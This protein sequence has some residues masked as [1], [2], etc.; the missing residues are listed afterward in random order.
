MQ[1]DVVSPQRNFEGVLLAWNSAIRPNLRNI[2]HSAEREAMFGAAGYANARA[3][4]L[5][6]GVQVARN[7]DEAAPLYAEL[8]R[9]LRDE[10]PWSFLYYYSDLLLVRERLQDVHMDIRGA[11]AG[12]QDWWVT[13]AASSRR[14]RARSDSAAR[15]P[16][17]AAAPGQ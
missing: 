2:F 4:S 5:I 15:S 3:D 13:D 17:P 14:A 6:D 9:L 1:G 7:S 11:L 10:Q 16:G 8:Q 12:V